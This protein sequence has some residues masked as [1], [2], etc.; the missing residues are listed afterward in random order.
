MCKLTYFK[1]GGLRNVE[2]DAGNFYW[3]IFFFCRFE[4]LQAE[5]LELAISISRI[6]TL[7]NHI[8]VVRVVR[9]GRVEKRDV[10]LYA[11]TNLMQFLCYILMRPVD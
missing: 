2:P 10:D 9:L 7:D 11:E 5:P 3:S 1:K 8:F 4:I 6:L